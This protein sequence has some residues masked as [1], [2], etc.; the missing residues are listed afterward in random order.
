MD[1]SRGD[2]TRD[3]LPWLKGAIGERL[4]REGLAG[5]GPVRDWPPSLANA[6]SLILQSAFPM[7]VVWGAQRR[8]VYNTAYE[9]ILGPKRT[10]ALGAPFWEVWPEVRARIEPILDAA[11]LGQDSYFENFPVTLNRGAGAE[12]AWFTFSYSPLFDDGAVSGALCVCVE[13][14]ASNRTEATLRFLDE[15]GAQVARLSDADAIMATTTRM[16]GEHL[17]VSI[18]AYAD[19]DPDEDGFTIRGDWSAPG[20]PSIVGRYRLAD[21][22]SLAVEKLSAGQPLVI[23]NNLEEIAPHEAATFQAIGISSTICM[24]LVKD[25]RLRALMAIHHKDPHA[26]SSHELSLLREVTE[27]SW[28]HVERVGA[29]AA[30]R[31]HAEQL[32]LA[33]DAA[34]IGLWDVDPLKD[35]LYWPPRVKAMFG[36]SAAAPVSM[37][38]DFFP[39]LHP[40]DLDRVSAAY[41]ATADPEVRALY[42]VEYRTIGKEDGVLRWVAAKGRG[43]FNDKGECVRVIGTAADITARKEA[44]RAAAEQARSLEVLNATGAAIAAELDLQKLVQMVT[45]AGVG[46]TGAQFGAFFYN[47][48]N[49][50]GESYT[51]YSLA[52]VDKSAFDTFPMPRNTKV[53]APTFTGEAVVRS[54]DI[55]QD[56]RYGLSSPHYGMPAGHLP[57]R[58][59]LAVP[60]ISRSG[61]VL[62]G[63]FF[64][65]AE[66]G[67][68]TPAAEQLM[69]G[70]A[71]QAAVAIDNA[72]LFQAAQTEIAQRRKVEEQQRL[73]INEL[74]HRVKNT[75]ATVQSIVAQTSKLSDAKSLR[76]TIESRLMALASA[77]D[78]LTQEN[79][80][81]A[82]LRDLLLR[83]L[84]P[85]GSD[86]S[87]RFSLEGP[88]VLLAPQ[89]ALAFAMATHELATN[90]VKY[91]S[92]SAPSGRIS[93][94]WR[95][96][97][98]RLE[99]E[100]REVDGPPV[101]A[102]TRRGF[103]SRLLERGLAADLQGEVGLEFARDGVR[104]RIAADLAGI[105][106][107][108]SPA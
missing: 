63:L 32:Q 102:P 85:F 92:L 39:C 16:V 51:L 29:E 83:S 80:E 101:L 86:L 68:F 12:A 14:T 56:P 23:N 81:G 25:G 36:I 5:A 45:D 50:E 67:V 87:A 84:S 27:R 40:E 72:Q 103:G 79:W 107:E 41:A 104:C 73:L 58:S 10:R 95:T 48:V 3:R 47:L 61:E 54:D 69:R 108:R 28:A 11:F 105:I 24:P 70:L 62:G 44:E 75:L 21:F 46:I 76:G 99:L 8:L 35:E 2:P 52:G 6:V 65:H 100:W 42:D 66:P 98:G 22:G 106:A 90:A 89:Q 71:G 9:A 97:A 64:G 94:S 49:E 38:N 78:L 34:E 60:V 93:I 96:E 91:G 82:E 74:N 1:D 53:F 7:F 13:T 30:L 17:G 37:A 15:L 4:A 19:M 59:Y 55:T 88:S 18:C 31:A 20:S 77:H 43:L 33:T 26:W 57:V